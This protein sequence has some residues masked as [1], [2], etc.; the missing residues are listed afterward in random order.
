MT[1]PGSN[2]TP[3]YQVYFRGFE[4]VTS[5]RQTRVGSAERRK[6]ALTPAG[7]DGHCVA[8]N[9]LYRDASNFKRYGR[10]VFRNP[11]RKP[12]EELNLIVR[13]ILGPEAP[14]PDVLH[15]QPERVGL[16]TLFFDAD[17]PTTIDDLDVHEFESIE[18]MA[19]TP[20]VRDP[21]T[22]DDLLY[23]LSR[24]QGRSN[25]RW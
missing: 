9:Y 16:P 8:F 24:F 19:E 12:I 14:F 20:R 4:A 7:N 13:L 10:V 25:V 23:Q 6:W 2:T 5:E 21:R 15:F 17:G 22:I 1:S 11:S 3:G 18:S